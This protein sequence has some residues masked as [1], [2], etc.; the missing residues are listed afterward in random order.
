MRRG[1][2]GT[3]C[4]GHEGCDSAILSNMTTQN[5]IAIAPTLLALARSGLT[6]ARISDTDAAA[7]AG[8]SWDN[9]CGLAKHHDL[10][11]LL[12]AGAAVSGIAAPAEAQDTLRKAS[13]IAEVRS[14]R[15][16]SQIA[17]ILSGFNQHGMAPMLLKGAQVA[18]RYYPSPGMRPFG[19]IDILVRPDERERAAEILLELGYRNSDDQA[20][21]GKAWCIANH[22]HWT[23]IRERL[24]HVE[25]HWDLSFPRSAVPLDLDSLWR[26]AELQNAPEGRYL[27]LAGDDDLL[28]L[29]CHITRHCFKIPLRSH[30]DIAAIAQQSPNLDW[31]ALLRRAE[32][33]GAAKDLLAVLAVGS[34]LGLL[35]LP[36]S[37]GELANDTARRDFDLAFLLRYAVECP[38]IACPERWLAVQLAPTRRV[39]AQRFWTALFPKYTHLWTEALEAQGSARPGKVYWLAWSRRAGR[40]LRGL[41]DTP[42]FVRDLRATARAYQMFGDRR[43]QNKSLD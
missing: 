13:R 32:T 26:R 29:A 7:M 28:F 24:L 15:A 37:V 2:C 20:G 38:Y 1:A 33:L 10:L 4:G 9:L 16:W 40:L 11:P 35:K 36:P 31:E 22:F 27:A 39:Q 8:M 43:G 18:R 21:D 3:Y 25:L 41:L 34:G 17:E 23:F 5:H 12:W 42:K 19:D 30:M 14:D 6:G